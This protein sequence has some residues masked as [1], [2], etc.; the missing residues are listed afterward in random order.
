MTDTP[1]TGKTNADVL[2]EAGALDPEDLSED[3]RKVVNEE[4]SP[5]EMETLIKMSKKLKKKPHASSAAF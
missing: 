2:I 4:F 1:E 3:H 5:E